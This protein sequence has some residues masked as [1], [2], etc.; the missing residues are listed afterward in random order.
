MSLSWLMAVLSAWVVLAVILL[1]V[2]HVVKVPGCLGLMAADIQSFVTALVNINHQLLSLGVLAVDGERGAA[3][4]V[5][6]TGQR[7]NTERHL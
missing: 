4:A 5:K 1:S 3:I 7:L 6:V 2:P